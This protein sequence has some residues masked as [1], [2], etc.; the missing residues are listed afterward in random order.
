M[1][2]K[3]A[4]EIPV[5]GELLEKSDQ[6]LTHTITAFELETRARFK[7]VDSQFKQVD[8]RFNQME[9]RFDQVDA[10]F[11]QVDA[12]FDKMDA[13]IEKVLEIATKNQM[14]IEELRNYMKFVIDGHSDLYRR[15]D[16]SE[17][18]INRLEKYNFGIGQK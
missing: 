7:E 6:R 18:R 5:T 12:R 17:S 2:V 9:A 4:K 8:A 14:M 13:K 3:K 1:V 10:R 11:D 16:E 15:Q